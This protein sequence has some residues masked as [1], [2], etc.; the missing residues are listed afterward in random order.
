[1]APPVVRAS[2][3][4]APIEAAS[5]QYILEF[6]HLQNAARPDAGSLC[7]RFGLPRVGAQFLALG[8]KR[9]QSA[10]YVLRGAFATVMSART[11][12]MNLVL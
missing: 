4:R 2:M 11:F 1:M 7:A 5:V 3:K 10:G 8:K 9:E 6:L 12:N